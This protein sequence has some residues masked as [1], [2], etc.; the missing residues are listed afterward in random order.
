MAAANLPLFQV[1]LPSLLK[2]VDRDSRLADSPE[3]FRF[4]VHVGFDDDDPFWSDPARIAEAIALAENISDGFPI[5]FNLS[6]Q[7]RMRGAPCWIWSQLFNRSC[8]GGCDY[9]YQLND[10]IKLLS[11]GW[12]AEFSSTLATNP[13]LSNFGIT[14]PLDT[15]NPRL[16]TQSFAHCMHGDIFSS[17][18]PRTFKNWYSDD[19]ATQVYGRH[20]TFWRRDIEVHHALAHMGPRY[21]IAYEDK[22]RLTAEVEKGR[23]MI[24]E[25]IDRAHPELTSFDS[26]LDG[27]ADA[28]VA[29]PS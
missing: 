10:D 22:Q 1:L 8:A 9:Y 7:S 17:Y 5:S 6:S 27:V 16:M 14:G 13:Y 23:S 2:T 18:Y 3:R 12:A 26:Q 15:N 21:D 20:N 29:P 19:W 4:E 11:P 28:V 25:Y 24:K